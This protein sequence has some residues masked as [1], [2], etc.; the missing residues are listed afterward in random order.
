M[1]ITTI[2]LGACPLQ[3]LS[4]GYVGETGARPVAF[5]FSAW[6]AEYG[7]GVLQLLFQRFGDAEPYPVVLDIDGETATWTPDATDTAAQGQGQAQ[8][9]YTV[10]GVI[11]KNAIFRVLI[12]PSLGAAGDPPEPYESWLERLTELAAETQQ[13]AL[14]AAE[15]AEAAETSAGAAAGSAGAA[16]QSA[17]DAEAAKTGAEA[18][19]TAAG[20]SAAAAAEKAAQAAQA[21]QTAEQS[22]LDAAESAAEAGQSAGVAEAAKTDA[23]TA[24]TAAETAATNAGT[25]AGSAAEKAAQAAQSAQ[26]AGQGASAAQQSATDAQ[27]A[28]EAAQLAADAAGTFA[29]DAEDSKTAAAQ[30]AALAALAKTDAETAATDAAASEASAAASAAVA[31]ELIDQIPDIEAEIDTKA[32]AIYKAAGPAA[33]VTVADGAEDMPMRQLVVDIP[34]TQSGSGDP[35]PEN[36]RPFI[37]RTSRRVTRAGAN[38]WGGDRWYD[39]GA[40]TFDRDARTVK[41]TTWQTLP[42]ITGVKYKAQTAYTLILTMTSTATHGYPGYV[43]RYTDGTSVNLND[44][45]ISTTKGTF[46][47]VSNPAKT[48]LRIDRTSYSGTKTFYVDESGIFEGALTAADFQPYRGQLIDIDW[49]DVAGDI[50][51]GTLTI[52]A[53]G[54]GTLSVLPHYASYAGETLA[55]PWVSSMDVYAEGTVPTTGAEVVDLG[56]AATLYQIT[57]EQLRTLAGVN[58]LWSN[59]GE[60]ATVYPADTKSYIDAQTAELTGEIETLGG[61]VDALD[62]DVA[63]LSALPIISPPDVETLVQDGEYTEE[64]KIALQ[65]A[66]GIWEP[67]WELVNDITLAEE[68]GYDLS[69]DSDGT[70]YNF[71]AVYILITYPAN[72]QTVTTGYARVV[73]TDDS[74]ATLTAETGKYTEAT[75]KTSKFVLTIRLGT[76]MLLPYARQVATGGQMTWAHKAATGFAAK[77][78]AIT[79]VNTFGTDVEPAGTNIKIYAQR[80]Y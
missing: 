9:V 73:V 15:S 61:E 62:G 56:G 46:A 42:Q 22:A 55:G 35:S 40:G 20:Q 76:A 32:P 59:A 39:S 47:F 58:N 1:E 23:E 26:T 16:A 31:Q 19:E 60:V 36:V 14:D 44:T 18:A 52:H 79:R 41:S 67:P 12:A 64:A 43:W 5:D 75:S 51:A 49:T 4:V 13:N 57:A 3:Y 72:L 68:Q 54:S 24:K 66:L 63:D 74:G 65:K 45:R 29:D 17:L 69:A 78:G 53:D 37:A 21:A 71:R 50:Y 10:G 8:L 6:A 25:S 48:L 28:L 7:A 27:A 38:L 80:A 77:F 34:A 2:N 11:V 33:V 70:P 30:S